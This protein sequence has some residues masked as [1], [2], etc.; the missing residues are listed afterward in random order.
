ME[1]ER[2]HHCPSKLPCKQD[3]D[4]GAST[5]EFALNAS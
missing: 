3:I 4:A 1:Y 5:K 2:V